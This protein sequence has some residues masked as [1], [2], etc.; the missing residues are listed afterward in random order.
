MFTDK[1]NRYAGPKF[2]RALKISNDRKFKSS[3]KQE[4]KEIKKRDFLMKYVPSERFLEEDFVKSS[5][6]ISNTI[7]DCDRK[8][9][10]KLK[11]MLPSELLPYKN[12]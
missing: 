10:E 5:L 3:A 11:E 2:L 8:V 4:I 12:I 9:I 6:I 7:L 1:V